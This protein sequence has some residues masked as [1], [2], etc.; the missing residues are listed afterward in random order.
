VPLLKG[1]RPEVLNDDVGFLDEIEEQ[2]PAGLLP[3]FSVTAFLLRACTVQ[4]K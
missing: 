3:R 2:R 4:K 1:A